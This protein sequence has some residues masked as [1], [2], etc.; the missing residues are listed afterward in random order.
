[1]KSVAIN[2][3]ANSS[4][5]GGRGPI[6]EDGTFRYIPIPE[7]NEAVMEPTYQDLNLD[8]IRPESTKDTVAHLDP[9]FPELGYS[10]HYT[11]GDRHQPKTARI[12]ELEE[13]DI[14]FFYATLDYVGEESPSQEWINDDWGAYIIGHFVL[15]HDPI[16]KEEYHSLPKNVKEQFE[17]NAHVRRDEFDAKYLVLGNPDDSR[18]YKTPLPLSGESGIEANQFVTEHSRASGEEGWYRRPLK[19]DTEGTRILLQ[20][21]RDYHD[22]RLTEPDVVSETEFDRTQLGEKGQLQWFFHASHSKYPVRDIV[23][24]GKTEPFLE[25]EAENFCSECYQPSVKTFAETDSRRYLFLFTRCQNDSL[26]THG[27]RRI[28]GYIDKK[29]SLKMGDRTAVQGDATLVSF[30]DSVDLIGIVD[31]PNYVRNEV[32]EEEIAQRLVEYF[33]E[34]ENV[35]NECLDEVERLKRKRREQ[36]HSDDQLPGSSGGC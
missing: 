32:L 2:V 12:A 1:M 9:E 17:T 20:A 8:P 35:L 31:S 36:E 28:V 7:G 27:E 13:G 30:E 10:N 11:Y 22:E 3:A 18:L 33:D 26:Y 24:R 5:T 6:Y 21:Q 34:Q 14:L 19:F 16:S 25:K 23:N 29:R 4:H 15:E